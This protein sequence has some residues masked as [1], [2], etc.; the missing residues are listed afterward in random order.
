MPLKSKTGRVLIIGPGP[1][2]IGHGSELDFAAVTA[3]DTL[4]KSGFDVL[5]VDANPAGLLTYA[6]RTYVAPISYESIVDIIKAEKPGFLLPIFGGSHALA[7]ALRLYSGGALEGIEIMGLDIDSIKTV[8][9]R[10]L[11]KEK[12]S[13]LG[14]HL[15][16]SALCMSIE[17]AERNASAFGYPVVARPAVTGAGRTSLVYNVEDLRIIAASITGASSPV[18]VEESLSG[19]EKLETEVLSDKSGNAVTAI[20]RENLDQMGIHSGD[21]VAVIPLQTVEAGIKEMMDDI[22]TMLARGLRIK[23]TANI[24]FGY[25]RQTGRLLVIEINPRYSRST[26]FASAATGINLAKAASRCA[27]GFTLKDQDL[28]K[29]PCLLRTAVRMPVFQFDKFEGAD[30]RLNTKMLSTG[31]SIGIGRDFS[32]AFLN[33]ARSQMTESEEEYADFEKDELCQ[34]LSEPTGSRFAII[35]QLLEKG[36]TPAE[37]SELTKIRPFFIEQMKD[38]AAAKA[39]GIKKQPIEPGEGPV[40]IICSGPS[41]IGEGQELSAMGFEAA[42]AV[43][44]LGIDVISV[45]SNPYGIAS[46]TGAGTEAMISPIDFDNIDGI[47]RNR[48]ARGVIC[49]TGGVNA[50]TVAAMLETAGMKIFGTSPEKASRAESREGLAGIAGAAGIL[51]PQALLARNLREVMSAAENIGYPVIIL[52]ETETPD[53]RSNVIA[54]DVESLEHHAQKAV[55]PLYVEKFLEGGFMA[56]VD[57]VCDGTEAFIPAIVEHV[58]H[59][60]IHTGDAACV[61]PPLNISNKNIAEIR[62][63]VSLISRHLG[64]MGFLNAQFAVHDGSVYCLGISLRASRTVPLVS[65]VTGIPMV[66]YAVR[67]MFG[68]KIKD[69]GIIEPE[70]KHYGVREAVF[71]FD[72]FAGVDP[73][74]GPEMRS[75]GQSLGMADNF[76]LAF[77]RS[78]EAAGTKLPDNGSVLITV[79]RKDRQP[80]LDVAQSLKILGFEICA[81]KGTA[82]FLGENG[83]SARTVLKVYEGRPNIVDDIKNGEYSLIINTPSGRLSRY[84]DSYIRKAA[85]NYKVPYITT[86]SGAVAA[87]KG[88]KATRTASAPMKP[89]ESSREFSSK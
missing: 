38:K 21:T 7:L 35:L 65:K 52:P 51:I 3:A 64:V 75:T 57:A 26:A 89:L 87:V 31:A 54:N 15:P 19:W 71:S 22:S 33:A 4:K 49:Q 83:I 43:K 70:L 73:L 1:V 55:F 61:V 42:N 56:Q 46:I 32:E 6:A 45:D 17:E 66:D 5:A 81:T 68:T 85:I 47:C 79:S 86:I 63:S 23:G 74:L 13:G 59:A 50:Q 2:R 16:K 67:A 20:F 27:A 78:L 37:I 44:S 80:L 14:V 88:I 25:E 30:D 48:S 28:E 9:D 41:R 8:S 58:E 84:D 77:S 39:T 60:G 69:M 12:L 82:K 53:G 10:M 11:L 18:M 29:L 36:G 72:V 24:Q 34:L 40:I 76:G 62:D